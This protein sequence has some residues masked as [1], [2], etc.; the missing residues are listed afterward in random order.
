MDH[1]HCHQ[2]MASTSIARR[3]VDVDL[4]QSLKIK[5]KVTLKV[6]IDQ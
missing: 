3:G 6:K 5:V 4:K 2:V 1:R